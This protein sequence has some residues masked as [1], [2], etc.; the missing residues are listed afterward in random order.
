MLP[1][2]SRITASCFAL[3]C[4]AAAIV[5]GLASGTPAV[6]LLWRSI[7]VML[8]AWLVGLAVGAVIQQVLDEHIETHRQ[9]NPMPDDQAE[10]ASGEDANESTAAPQAG[11][12]SPAQS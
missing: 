3:A 4:F 6:T 7:V 5:V 11:G 2:P 10:A 8:G 1:I 9:Q 12:E